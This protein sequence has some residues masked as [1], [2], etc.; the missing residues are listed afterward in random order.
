MRKKFEEFVNQLN[1]EEFREKINTL[2]LHKVLQFYQISNTLCYKVLEYLNIQPPKKEEK[3]VP[4]YKNKCFE[5]GRSFTSL[6]GLNFHISQ[7]HMP[8]KEYYDKYLKR[9]GEGEC[10]MCGKPTKFISMSKGYTLHCCDRCS[11]IDPVTL[12]K[13]RNTNQSRR[14][15]DNPFQD[16]ELMLDA[17]RTKLGVDNPFQ[18]EEVK[19]KIRLK[20]NANLGVDYPMQS[21]VIKEKSKATCN[22]KYDA[23]YFLQSQTSI[24]SRRQFYLDNFNTTC[25]AQTEEFHKKARKRYTFDSLKF[26]SLW[27]VA[28]YI[29][30]KNLGSVIKRLPIKFTYSAC[31]K[32]HYYFPD[33]EIDGKLVEVK[34]PQFL[35]EDKNLISC[36]RDIPIEITNAKNKCIKENNIEIWSSEEVKDAL[37]YFR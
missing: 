29:Y 26:D 27:E 14:G 17:Y 1:A 34:G 10:I 37:D 33:F 32:D 3:K 23:P 16:R 24:N 30:Y 28:I 12:E 31:G 6:Q 13:Q 5:C 9:P 2:P 7:L 36:Y 11:Q 22:E 25:Y 4:E 18:S 8:L 35:D 21:D 15:I 20:N 19:E